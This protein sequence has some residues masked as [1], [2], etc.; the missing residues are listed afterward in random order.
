MKE[1]IVKNKTFIPFI[2]DEE[3]Q[4]AVRK[5]AISLHEEFKD[6]IPI[7]VGVLSG[8]VMFLSDFLKHYPGSCEVAFMKLNSYSGTESTGKVTSELDITAEITNRHI[9]ILEDIVDTGNTLVKLHELLKN[10]PVK[11]LKVATLFFKPDVYKK[12]LPI[13]LIGIHIPNKFVLGYG[14][15]YDGLGRNYQDLYQLKE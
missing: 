12:D 8:V 3:I 1:I 4:Q 11:S 14:L 2:A 15:D 9:V 5:I 7:F 13:D 6:E 10:K